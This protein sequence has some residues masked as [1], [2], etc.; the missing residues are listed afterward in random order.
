[1]SDSSK[2]TGRRLPEG[3]RREEVFRFRANDRETA[4]IRRLA[5]RRDEDDSKVIRAGV[6]ALEREHDEAHGGAV[7]EL[8]ALLRARDPAAALRRVRELLRLGAGP[9]IPAP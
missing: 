8:M 9:A 7:R 4:R 5:A 6:E 2:P 3:R 1:M